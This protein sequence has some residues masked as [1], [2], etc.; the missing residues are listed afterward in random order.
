MFGK[1]REM[2]TEPLQNTVKLAIAALVVAIVALIAAVV[3]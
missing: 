2:I 3:R 1:T